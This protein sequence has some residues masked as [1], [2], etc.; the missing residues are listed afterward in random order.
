VGDPDYDDRL[1]Q[2]LQAA[3]FGYDLDVRLLLRQIDNMAPDH[4]TG[5]RI[6][7]QRLYERLRV[8][9]AALALRP[10]RAHIILFDDVL[11]SGKHY[12][13]CQ[14]RL[15]E[16]LPAIPISGWFIARRVLPQR[17]RA[18]PR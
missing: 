4:R 8:D 3:F 5:A 2:T 6:R 9:A 13:C 7:E 10:L 18:I 16:S 15:R 11:V 14:K 17:W 1:W 12:R